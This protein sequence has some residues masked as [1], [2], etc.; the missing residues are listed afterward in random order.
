V[1]LTYDFPRGEA[2]G[3]DMN[4]SM[5]RYRFK[6]GV[7]IGGRGFLRKILQEE[8]EEN[9]VT[10]TTTGGPQKNSKSWDNIKFSKD[11]SLC[12]PIKL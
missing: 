12:I 1:A 6:G 4:S 10:P 9:V 3:E 5:P 2:P 8:N 7:P 11:P